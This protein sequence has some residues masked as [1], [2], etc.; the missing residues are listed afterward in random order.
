[1]DVKAFLIG[2]LVIAVAVLGYMV[3][4]GQRSK[5]DIRLPG[6]TIKGS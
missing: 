5:V 4:D 1:M 3:W 6:V 2:G